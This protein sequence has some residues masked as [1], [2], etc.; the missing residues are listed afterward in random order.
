MMQSLM[1]VEGYGLIMTLIIGGL[2]GWIAEMLTKA[3]HGVLTNIV[4]GVLGAFAARW[5]AG[6]LGIV[7]PFGGFIGNLIVATAGAVV[8]ITLYRMIKQRR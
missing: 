1:G 2:A 4:V 3:N 5:A 6:L 8:L 7:L